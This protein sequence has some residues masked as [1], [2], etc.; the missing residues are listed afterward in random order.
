MSKQ[1]RAYSLSV[2]CV[3]GLNEAKND[4]MA[5]ISKIVEKALEEY[6]PKASILDPQTSKAVISVSIS[7]E[8]ADELEKLCG[9][10]ISKSSVV[11]DAVR[12]Y[13]KSRG[14]MDD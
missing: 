1:I 5:S 2:D 14:Y 3:K 11:D 13:L 9:T 4:T 10:S 12:E 6:L 7:D 8:M